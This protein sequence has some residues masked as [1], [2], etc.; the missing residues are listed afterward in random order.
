[1]NL[2]TPEQR[3]AWEE[4]RQT[5]PQT[6][7]KEIAVFAKLNRCTYSSSNRTAKLVGHE[8]FLRHQ[9]LRGRVA[10]VPYKLKDGS[11]GHQIRTCRSIDPRSVSFKG[12]IQTLEAFQPEIALQGQHVSTF[13][14][15]LYDQLLDALASH[16]VADRLDRVEPRL[17]KR[18]PKHYGYLRKPRK[19]SKRD[20]L[21]CFSKK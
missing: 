4:H 10:V 19:E 5:F 16:R 2:L 12:A 9:G 6:R 13:S 3:E 1:L 8:S 18:R 17:R 20:I 7:G 21:K 11:Y 14:R 15:H